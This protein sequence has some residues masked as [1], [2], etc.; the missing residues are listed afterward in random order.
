MRIRLRRSDSSEVL[1]YGSG[2]L[3]FFFNPSNGGDS[4]EKFLIAVEWNRIPLKEG[5]V[6]NFNSR[7]EAER[8]V[9]ELNA[10]YD[11][12]GIPMKLV[13]LW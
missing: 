1:D 8:Y 12:H 2:P 6:W 5:Y 13:L 7:K 10:F 11:K 3:T 9:E 4:M